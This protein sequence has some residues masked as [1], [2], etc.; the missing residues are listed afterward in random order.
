MQ[1]EQ[2]LLIAKPDLVKRGLVHKLLERIEEKGFK[3]VAARLFQ[4]SKCDMECHYEE[5]KGKDFFDSLVTKMSSDKCMFLIVEGPEVVK[6][7]RK[8]IGATKPT[9]AEPG[10]LRSLY[11]RS[12]KE[13]AV[14]GSDSLE[15]AKR[16]I[17]IWKPLL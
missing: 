10:S 4:P 6:W 14:H 1:E 15:S 5:H 11:G 2:T 12:D 16:E 8:I 13:N 7:S 9:D 17:A 3:I